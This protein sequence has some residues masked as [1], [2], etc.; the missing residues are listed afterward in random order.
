MEAPDDWNSGIAST[1]I[2]NLNW[3]AYGL[4]AS[5]DDLSA[6]FVIVI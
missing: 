2:H 1:S 3:R 5:N 6:F 4:A